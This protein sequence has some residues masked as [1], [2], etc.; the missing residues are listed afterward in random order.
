LVRTSSIAL[1]EVLT[2]VLKIQLGIRRVGPN[3]TS[4]FG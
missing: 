4:E 1:A 3:A 2:E